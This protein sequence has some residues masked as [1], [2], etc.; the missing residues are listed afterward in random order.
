MAPRGG[1]TCMVC[2]CRC[3]AKMCRMKFIALRC[4]CL[5]QNWYLV[6][7]DLGYPVMSK[8]CTCCIYDIVSKQHP[9]A[10]YPTAPM[11]PTLTPAAH[12]HLHL[13]SHLQPLPQFA[14]VSASVA[15]TREQRP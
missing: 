1:S 10:D 4:L 5:M 11:I 13:H 7:Y 14:S 12:P 6:K 9:M 15:P 2:K 8:G 3:W